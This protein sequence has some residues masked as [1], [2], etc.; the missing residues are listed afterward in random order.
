MR[1]WL[2][3]RRVTLG[4]ITSTDGALHDSDEPPIGVLPVS[5]RD[6]FRNDGALGVFPDVDH[7]GARLPHS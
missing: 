5:R 1:S 2:S 6:P 3:T 7:L 4:I